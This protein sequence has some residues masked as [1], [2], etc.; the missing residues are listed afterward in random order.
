[1][2]IGVKYI[3]PPQ[4]PPPPPPNMSMHTKQGKKEKKKEKLLYEIKKRCLGIYYTCK[5]FEIIII[6]IIFLNDVYKCVGK[7]MIV[8]TLYV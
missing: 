4:P 7:N 6:I 2:G 1:L 8:H 5:N 3:G